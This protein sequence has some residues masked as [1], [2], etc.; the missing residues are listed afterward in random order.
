MEAGLTPINLTKWD[1]R[2]KGALR[3]MSVDVSMS[4][5]RRLELL[6]LFSVRSRDIDATGRPIRIHILSDFQEKEQRR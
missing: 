4:D 3:C 1:C 6:N 5:A 2:G